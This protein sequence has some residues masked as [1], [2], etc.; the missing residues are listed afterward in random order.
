MGGLA[1]R[2]KSCRY[3]S[4]FGWSIGGVKLRGERRSL[5]DERL[6]GREPAGH[7]D[8]D[9]GD[10]SP[11]ATIGCHEAA[12]DDTALGDHD[13]VGD[14]WQADRLEIEAKLIGPEGGQRL[15]GTAC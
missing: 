15:V 11:L 5:L 13:L 1:V 7:V 3:G 12:L 4:Q 14:R 6:I 9:G 10:H 2:W 8:G